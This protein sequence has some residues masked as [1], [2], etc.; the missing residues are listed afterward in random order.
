MMTKRKTDTHCDIH[1]AHTWRKS[2][3]KA[4]RLKIQPA[5]VSESCNFQPL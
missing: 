3:E 2:I 5:N 1:R 4:V